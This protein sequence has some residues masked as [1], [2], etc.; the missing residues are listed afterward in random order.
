ML[1]LT[2]QWPGNDAHQ[3]APLVDVQ[4]ITD[5]PDET[6]SVEI[7][8]KTVSVRRFLSGQPRLLRSAR[9]T[10]DSSNA[11]ESGHAGSSSEAPVRLRLTLTANRLLIQRDNRAVLNLD[12]PA[13]PATKPARVALI[14]G[15]AGL[16]VI[17]MRLEGE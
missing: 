5:I 4:F 11:D 1:E 8:S 6:L 3:D 10:S 16:H 17:D 12:R 13:P 9:F 15:A 2:V 7:T 14:P